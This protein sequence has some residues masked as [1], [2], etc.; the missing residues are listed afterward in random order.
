M[1]NLERH[2]YSKV[3]RGRDSLQ[4]LKGKFISKYIADTWRHS[5]ANFMESLIFPGPINET[6]R[7]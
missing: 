4:T 2:V 1:L 5:K 6:D 3:T 7:E